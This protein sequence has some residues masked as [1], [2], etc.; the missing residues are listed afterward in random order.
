[1]CGIF[2]VFNQRQNAPQ[3]SSLDCMRNA[4]RHRG[5]D[6]SGEFIDDIGAIGNTRLSI[7]DLE[8]RSNQPLISE[9]KQTVEVANC[10]IYNYLEIRSELISYGISFET[11]G[12]VEVILKSFEYWG[13]DF[14]EKLNGMFAIAILS[15][16]EKSLYLFRDR[17][18]VKP[19]FY[20][21]S[22][23]SNQF[24][25]ASEIKAINAAMDHKTVS[26]VAIAEFFANKGFST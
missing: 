5:P 4:L 10:E 25:F 12:D 15:L 14:V 7:V 9:D 16:Q 2:G 22:P 23:N 13:P 20:S 26:D 8:E 11:N 1:M 21:I 19:L 6:A 24:F 3:P 18:G 17:L